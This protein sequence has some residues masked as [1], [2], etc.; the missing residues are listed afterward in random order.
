MFRNIILYPSRIGQKLYGVDETPQ[1]IKPLLNQNMNIINTTVKNNLF[2]SLDN[3]YIN[4]LFVKGPRINIGGDHSMSIAT[5]AH[6]L[7]LYPNL[8]VIWMDAHPDINT[9]YSSTTKNIH[10]MPLSTL[11]GIENKLKFNF[12]SNQLNT[13]N[14][15][16]IGIRDIDPFEQYIIDKFN[17]KVLTI[18]Q[19]NC[20]KERNNSINIINNFIRD[21]PVHLSFDVDVLDPSI[22]Y[23]TGTPVK[24]GLN[25][26]ACKDILLYL[27]NKN[28]VSFD[29]TE[30]N[31]RIGDKKEVIKSLI[32][33][34]Y[35]LKNYIN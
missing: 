19:I 9:Y 24:N 28:L 1:L 2:T 4:N 21:S 8:K 7:R 29:L 15:L 3:L 20:K 17:I 26:D 22:I 14:L 11:I 16:Y 18:E 13:D 33:L 5:V 6:S 32:S 34:S 35:L 27:I 30:L 31:L 25:L 23:S 12:I 10:G